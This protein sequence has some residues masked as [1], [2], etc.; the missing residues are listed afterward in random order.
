MKKNEYTYIECDCESSQHV[1]RFAYDPE[2]N[3]LWV[4]AQLVQYRNFWQRLWASIKYV[5]GYKCKYGHWD[6]TQISGEQAKRLIDVLIKLE[7]DKSK[8]EEK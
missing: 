3:D 5:F 2:E 1:L 7:A 4:E 6:C 8:K